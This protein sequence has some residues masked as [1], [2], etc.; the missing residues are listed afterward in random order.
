[1]DRTNKSKQ[2]RNRT[3]RL[4]NEG[5][6][7]IL[8]I[9]PYL[10]HFIVFIAF[11]LLAS[12]YFS[13]SKYDMLNSP[14]WIGLDNYHKLIQDPVFWKSFWN[15]I[16][17]TVLFVPTQTILALILAV[18]LNQQ[19]KGLKFYRMAHFIPVI[20]SWTVVLYVADAIFNPRFGLANDIL[21]KLGLQPQQWLNDEKLVIPVL[22]LVAVWKG[23]GYMMVIFLAGLQNV[24]EDLYE[25]ADIEGAGVL[26]KFRHVTI[27]LISATTFLVLV[28]ST[29]TTFQ[30]FEQIYVMTGNSGDITAAGGPNN[31]SMVL[32]LYLFQQGF[33]FLK[34]GYASAIA[35][36][37]FIMLFLITLIQVKLQNKW[38]HYEK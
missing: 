1:M 31:A 16:Y 26:K 12:L 20:S 15:T 35:W 37:L 11:T 30:A 13:F 38:V 24:P 36:V 14:E 28:L 3:F 32:M 23:I 8:M 19:L 34:M 2:K 4:S 18:A 27:P 9:S 33:A 17:F 25:A 29:I 10:I 21:L 22:V 6:W 5:K 7:G